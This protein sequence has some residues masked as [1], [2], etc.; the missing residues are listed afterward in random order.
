ME[1]EKAGE[2]IIDNE[3]FSIE[4]EASDDLCEK[5]KNVIN[6]DDIISQSFH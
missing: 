3:V 4:Q 1:T 2:V 5:I 6:F